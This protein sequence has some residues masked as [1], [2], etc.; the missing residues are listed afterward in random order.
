MKFEFRLKLLYF[1]RDV[2]IFFSLD[3]L[4]RNEKSKWILQK[5]LQV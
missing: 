5:L 4:L 2:I 1:Q 3:S